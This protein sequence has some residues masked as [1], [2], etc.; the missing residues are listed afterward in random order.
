MKSRTWILLAALA[1][2]CAPPVWAGD[3]E[4]RE[5]PEDKQTIDILTG[6][7]DSSTDD[8]LQRVAEYEVVES[9]PLLGLRWR[10]SPYEESTMGLQITRVD[11]REYKA[12]TMVPYE[13]FKE[14]IA[15]IKEI[16]D[17]VKSRTTPAPAA[18]PPASKKGK[19]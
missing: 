3:G 10:T 18:A 1:L 9:N 6:G 4:D 19:R 11:S 14:R 13:Q 8:S 5:P 16:M 2:L 15:G 12:R 17:V 7:Q